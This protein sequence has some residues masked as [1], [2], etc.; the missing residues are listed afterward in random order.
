MSSYARPVVMLVL[1]EREKREP[2]KR[3]KRRLPRA[4][5][6]VDISLCSGLFECM[7][8]VG[9]SVVENLQSSYL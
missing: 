7:R 9:A 2:S 1:L 3:P 4:R 6:K 5:N 8:E